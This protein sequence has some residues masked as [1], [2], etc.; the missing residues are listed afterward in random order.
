M[1]LSDIPSIDTGGRRTRFRGRPLADDERAGVRDPLQCL[2]VDDAAEGI[3]GELTTI[4]LVFGVMRRSSAS[5]SSRQSGIESYG[6]GEAPAIAPA[7]A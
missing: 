6:T 5:M 1:T 4:S 2:A 3:D 7:S